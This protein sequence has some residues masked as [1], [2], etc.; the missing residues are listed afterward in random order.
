MLANV[1]HDAPRRVEVRL[2]VYLRHAQLAVAED[3][4]ARFQ[5]EPLADFGA[6]QVAESVRRPERH[7]SFLARPTDAPAVRSNVVAIARCSPSPC[8]PLPL[9]LARRHGALTL[10]ATLRVPALFR[11]FRG[12]Q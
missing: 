2:G 3:C 5:A 12:K 4:L 7:A 8:L 6:A 9:S 1:R 11:S 10:H